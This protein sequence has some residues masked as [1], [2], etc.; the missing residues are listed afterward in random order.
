[1]SGVKPNKAEMAEIVGKRSFDRKIKKVW[2]EILVDVVL[3][4]FLVLLMGKKKIASSGLG[5]ASVLRR[6]SRETSSRKQAVSS[7]VSSRKAKRIEK[8]TSPS[9]SPVKDKLEKIEKQMGSYPLRM[10]DRGKKL[11]DIPNI[12]SRK[13]K[14]N[15]KHCAVDINEDKKTDQDPNVGSKKRKRLTA[16]R[17]KASFKPQRL[18]IESDDDEGPKVEGKSTQARTSKNEGAAF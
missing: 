14:T 11:V 3:V 7:S 5:D 18:R 12:S 9:S 6:S 2:H 15:S 17:Y 8:R 10:S 13:E 1:M 16:I 4:Q